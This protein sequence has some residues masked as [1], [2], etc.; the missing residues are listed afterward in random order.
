MQAALG[1]YLS[2]SP[3]IDK[4][5]FFFHNSVLVDTVSFL[6]LCLRVGGIIPKQ[7][8]NERDGKIAGCNHWNLQAHAEFQPF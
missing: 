5:L 1:L 6:C 4:F 3:G 7:H 2:K 8:V